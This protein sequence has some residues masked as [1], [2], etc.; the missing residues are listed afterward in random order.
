MTSAEALGADGAEQR[1]G[2]RMV[3]MFWAGI[4]KHGARL[5]VGHG[6]LRNLGGQRLLDAV[7][8]GEPHLELY[9]APDKDD[10]G[11]VGFERRVGD[12]LLSRPSQ[13]ADGAAERG[14]DGTGRERDDLAQ[15]CG[16]VER[17]ARWR[18]QDERGGE[19]GFD[20]QVVQGPTRLLRLVVEF[21]KEACFGRDF[22]RKGAA[23]QPVG[24]I[25][26]QPRGPLC[27]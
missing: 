25:E 4:G 1:G 8:V 20:E 17:I 21:T 3:G 27:G 5:F 23:T 12:P 19:D 18:R 24:Q 9:D 22:A 13:S 7:V 2:R 15:Q 26:Q 16:V 14:R 11:A 6:K 10:L